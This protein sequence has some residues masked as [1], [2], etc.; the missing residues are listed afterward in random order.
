MRSQTENA[1]PIAYCEYLA[2]SG[3]R[4]VKGRYVLENAGLFFFLVSADLQPHLSRVETEIF[5]GPNEGSASLGE[6]ASPE[7][8]GKA[9]LSHRI[10][11]SGWK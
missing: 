3:G 6:D 11:F 10:F 7:L 4:A 9:S 8:R 1:Q 2:F 5:A